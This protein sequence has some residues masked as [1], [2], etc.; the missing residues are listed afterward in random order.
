M[1]GIAVIVFAT[2][3]A[4]T[5]YSDNPTPSGG[6]ETNPPQKQTKNSN[7]SPEKDERGAEKSPLIIKMVD[8]PKSEP[9]STKTESL[10]K[11]NTP[12]W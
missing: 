11:Q 8:A 9:S 10:N 2:L 3:V 1:L 7:K 5:A 12:D 4:N 6:K